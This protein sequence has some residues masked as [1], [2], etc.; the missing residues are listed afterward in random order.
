MNN[1]T[2]PRGAVLQ[3]TGTGS[4]DV[5]NLTEQGLTFLLFAMQ[6]EYQ[7]R[8]DELLYGMLYAEEPPTADGSACEE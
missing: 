1:S 3:N 7:S 5:V 4:H 6:V 8:F 2:L